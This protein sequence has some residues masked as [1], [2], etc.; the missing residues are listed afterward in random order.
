M[1]LI[2]GQKDMLLTQFGFP[3]TVSPMRIVLASS[4]PYRRAQLS[5][6]G[7]QFEAV[8][9]HVNEDEL[10]AQGPADPA[11]LTRYL[12]GAKAE[13]LRAEFP[14]ALILGSDQLVD[15]NGERLDKPGTLENARAQLT[16]LAGREHRLITSLAIN[17][18][19]RHL[20]FTDITRI[21]LKKLTPEE[22]GA[23]VALDQPLDCAGA[24]KIERAGMALIEKMETSD[25]SAIQGLPLLSLAR[26]FEKLGLKLDQLWSA[27]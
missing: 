23:Y 16:R 27:K 17:T 25:P 13:S 2:S 4:S 9:P 6:F 14:G 24:Y 18:P 21:R 26:G 22:I 12:A 1:R 19:D 10:K 5:A 15:F 8:K 11:E 20:M 7:L 3:I